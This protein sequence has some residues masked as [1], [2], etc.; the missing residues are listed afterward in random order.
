MSRGKRPKWMIDT[1]TERMDVL[2]TEA[3]NC[4][5]ENPARSHRYVTLARKISKKYNTP[6]PPQWKRR[7]CKNCYRF[8]KPGRNSVSRIVNGVVKIECLDCGHITRIP[9]TREQKE[10]RRAKIEQHI[11]KRHNE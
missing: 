3:E 7:Y 6:I 10:K 8:L 5:N 1:A 9:T 4:F 11:Q 2:F